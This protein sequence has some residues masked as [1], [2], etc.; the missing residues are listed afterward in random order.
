MSE[1]THQMQRGKGGKKRENL[2]I[3]KNEMKKPL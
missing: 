3:L 1:Y 2:S